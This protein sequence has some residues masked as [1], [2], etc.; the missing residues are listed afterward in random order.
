MN[1]TL[2]GLAHHRDFLE[3]IRSGG[4]P[5]ADVEIGHLSATLVHLG[6]IA[7]RVGRRLQFDPATEK[8]VGDEEAAKLVRRTY[9]ENHWAIPKGA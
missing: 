9:R 8:I 3:C 1:G 2:N 5:H 7:T 6:T 4:R